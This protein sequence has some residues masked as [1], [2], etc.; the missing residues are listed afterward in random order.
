MATENHYIVVKTAAPWVVT[1]TQV[2]GT[3]PS[4]ASDETLYTFAFTS[5]VK[6]PGTQSFSSVT[7]PTYTEWS[8][9]TVRTV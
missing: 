1:K 2:G 7:L 5:T 4:P 6:G 3:S 8:G 9:T